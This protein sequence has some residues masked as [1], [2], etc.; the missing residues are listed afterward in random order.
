MC[1]SSYRKFLSAKIVFSVTLCVLLSDIIIYLTGVMMTPSNM[2]NSSFNY[3]NDN[4]V[5]YRQNSFWNWKYNL[6]NLSISNSEGSLDNFSSLI[7]PA[8]I[9]DNFLTSPANIEDNFL[10]SPANIEDNFSLLSLTSPANLLPSSN[11]TKFASYIITNPCPGIVNYDAILW[12]NNLIKAY[13][14]N[15][16][17]YDNNGN[18]IYTIIYNQYKLYPCYTFLNSSNTI[19][20]LIKCHIF[21]NLKYQV[22]DPQGIVLLDAILDGE[23]WYLNVHEKVDI[24]LYALLL[25]DIS[26]QNN[27]NNGEIDACNA[28]FIFSFTIS[29]FILF[30]FLIICLCVVFHKKHKKDRI[31]RKLENISSAKEAIF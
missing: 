16:V 8:N 30:I 21:N 13:I 15:N 17:I 31:Y 26:F 4:T 10:T 29:C 24:R 27:R 19:V 20:A 9:E 6:V 22:L 23:D 12:E 14:N 25:S 11:I 28:Y 7:S 5:L 18:L 2:N 3:L 1:Y